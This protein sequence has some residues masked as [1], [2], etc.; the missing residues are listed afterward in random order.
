MGLLSKYLYNL[1]LNISHRFFIYLQSTV[2]MYYIL[3]SRYL[4]PQSRISCPTLL[5]RRELFGKSAVTGPLVQ[6]RSP[7]LKTRH[8]RRAR[9][10]SSPAR[11]DWPELGARSTP[12]NVEHR[13]LF[14]WRA[15]LVVFERPLPGRK[16]RASAQ[17]ARVIE[18][19]R[20]FLSAVIIG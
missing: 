14:P 11:K 8:H 1:I 2:L 6:P 10:P 3:K 19:Y 18:Y 20:S 9:G 13:A 15:R 4:S 12:A 17:T 7:T 16:R 5:D